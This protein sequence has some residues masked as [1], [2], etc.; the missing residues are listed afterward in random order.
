MAVGRASAVVRCPFSAVQGVWLAAHLLAPPR[1]GLCSTPL[2]YLWS[3]SAPPFAFMCS[4]S[5]TSVLPLFCLFYLKFLRFPT[6]T[7]LHAGKGRQNGGRQFPLLLS[8]HASKVKILAIPPDPAAAEARPPAH[9][10]E[11]EGPSR[12]ASRAATRDGEQQRGHLPDFE[13]RSGVHQSAPAFRAHRDGGAR[14]N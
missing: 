11:E 10:A 5:S 13:G 4:T 2:F 7:A 6:C 3:T 8:A 14:Q 1:T 9:G 12:P